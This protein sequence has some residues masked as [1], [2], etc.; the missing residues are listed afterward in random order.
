MRFDLIQSLSI[1][2]DSHRPNDDRIGCTGRLAWVIDG[3]T[4][5]GPPGLVGTQGGAAWIA[6]AANAAFAAADDRPIDAMCERV[7]AQ[8]ARDFGTVRT[9]D[10]EGRWELPSAA[11][12]AAR[13]GPDGIELA[14]AAD[15]SALIRRGDRVERIGPQIDRAIESHNAAQFIGHGLGAADRPGAITD[16]LRESRARLPRQVLGVE[17]LPIEE[18]GLAGVAAA[19]GDDVLLMSDGFAALVD[20]YAALD[21]EELMASLATRGLVELAFELRAIE[22]GDAACTRFPRFKRSDD[23]SALWLRVAD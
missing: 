22:A 16:M 6:D 15:C 8:V 21:A 13:A 2:G 4:D 20:G 5:L 19:P 12:L 7:F 17:P 14:W 9:R 10:A 11:F 23:A 18:L 1:A 3:A